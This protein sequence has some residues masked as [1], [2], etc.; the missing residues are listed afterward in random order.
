[1]KILVV[2]DEPLVA[3]FLRRGLVAEGH[4][5]TLAGDGGEGHAYALAGGFDVILLDVRLPIRSGLEVCS[6]LRGA[7][8]ATPILMLTALDAVAD[9]VEGLKRGADDYL[10]KPYA[11]EEL[12]ARI[13]AL[14]RRHTRGR[15]DPRA[16]RYVHAD[17]TLDRETLVV[18]RGQAIIALTAREIGILEMLIVR[19]GV[20]VSRERILSSVWGVQVDPLTNIIDV[21]IGRLRRKLGEHGA[22]IIETVRGFGYRLVEP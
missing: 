2:E 22:P 8:V 14:A 7:G 5:V 3:D 20:V 18:T 10:I 4:A 1:M 12:I 16:R 21:Y 13:Q 17:L 11:F 15:I 19:P 6:A 9:R